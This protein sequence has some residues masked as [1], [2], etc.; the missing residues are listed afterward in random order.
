[1]LPRYCLLDLETAPADDC[2]QWLGTIEAPKNYVKEDTIAAYIR[3]ETER[4]VQGAAFDPDLCKIVCFGVDLWSATSTSTVIAR[5][6]QDECDGL[7]W[8]WSSTSQTC[9]LVGYGL[10]W[11]DAGVLVRRSQLLGVKVPSAFYKQ[12]KYRHEMIVEL[13]DYLTLNGMIEQKK[14]RGLEYHCQRFG[15]TVDDEFTGKDIPALWAEG[16]HDAVRSHCLADLQRIRLLA[17]RLGVI[18]RNE[19]ERDEL[20]HHQEEAVL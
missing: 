16:A 12:G 9:P 5:D 1:M 15:I 8:I 17:E 10:T 6:R 11:F 4:R 3:D 13:A 7:E 19:H 20:E 18:P 2:R 14:G